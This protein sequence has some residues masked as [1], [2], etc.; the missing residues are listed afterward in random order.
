MSVLLIIN[1]MPYRPEKFSECVI[2][3]NMSS[4]S[5]STSDNRDYATEVEHIADM[6]LVKYSVRHSCELERLCQELEK[7]AINDIAL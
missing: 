3:T 7:G 2:S 6:H 5:P 4:H 1:P